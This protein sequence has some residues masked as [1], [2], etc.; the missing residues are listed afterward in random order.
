MLASFCSVDGYDLI[1]SLHLDSFC[2]YSLLV[3]QGARS[4]SCALANLALT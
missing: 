4:S 2:H 3:V 1:Y